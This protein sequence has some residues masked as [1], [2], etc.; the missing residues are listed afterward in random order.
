VADIRPEPIRDAIQRL[1][2]NPHLVAAMKARSREVAPY[3]SWQAQE[4]KYLDIYTSAYEDM[5]FNIKGA[6]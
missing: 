4:R 2:D 1:L 6:A 3:V 5:L